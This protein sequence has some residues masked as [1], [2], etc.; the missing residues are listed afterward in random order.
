MSH[1]TPGRLHLGPADAAAPRFLGGRHSARS[2]ATAAAVAVAV[3]EV[4]L[5]LVDSR[6]D[7]GDPV[8]V[9]VPVP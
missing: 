4:E 9:W 5:T 1:P 8:L 7:V 6:V 3:E 2:L